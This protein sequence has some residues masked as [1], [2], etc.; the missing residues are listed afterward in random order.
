MNPPPS[1]YCACDTS[2]ACD[3]NCSCDPE[4]KKGGCSCVAADDSS[5]AGSWALSVLALAWL[6]RRKK[7]RISG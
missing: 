7:P 4:C 2:N 3:P 1:D 5:R 6:A